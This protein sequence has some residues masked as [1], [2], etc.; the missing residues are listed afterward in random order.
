LSLRAVARRFLCAAALLSGAASAAAA[1]GVRVL[2]FQLDNDQ[3]AFTP[4]RDE[5]WYTSG[6]FLRIAFETPR[7]APDA[8]LAAA[9]CSHV[10]GC[11]TGST[12][13]RVWSLGHAIYTPQF[14]GT[15]SPQPDD[16]PYAAALYGGVATVVHGEFVR[17]TLELKLGVVG[18]AALGEE[19]QNLLHRI[20]G[21]A[22][23][24]GW[25][26]QVRAQPLVALGWSRLSR[27]RLGSGFD[28]VGRTALELGTPVTQAGA[29][30]I[31]RMGRLADGPAWPGEIGLA[32]GGVPGAWQ[33]YAGL[34]INAVARNRLVDGMTYG[35]ASQVVTE[36]WGGELLAGGML[37]LTA[38]WQLAYTFA[39]RAV[40]FSAPNRGRALQAQRIGSIALRWTPSR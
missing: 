17:Q 27:H 21:Q 5:R 14:P 19:V 40:E 15:Q 20:I 28:W 3:F 7:D 26:W 1:G 9:W 35:Y 23:V 11:D 22:Q 6:E 24:Q 30:A 12:I 4:A 18:P 34:Q 8:R 36:P 37:A 33:L 32:S 13:H 29:G 10:L 38:E 25:Q 31:V 39:L 16:R 2:E